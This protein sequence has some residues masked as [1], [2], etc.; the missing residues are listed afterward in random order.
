MPKRNYKTEAIKLSNSDNWRTPQWLFDQL[1]QEFN[2]QIDLCADKANA[3][4]PIFYSL[5][6]NAL[7]ENNQWNKTSFANVP[8]SYAKP[9][10]IKAYEQSR[11]HNVTIVILLRVDTSNNW[12]FD[13][14][15]KKAS[16]T[17]F[18]VGRLRF[19]DEQNKPH[20][21][22]K[23][24]NAILVYGPDY[25]QGST[26]GWWKY[27]ENEVPECLYRFREEV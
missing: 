11:K 23:W 22:A 9:F 1:N 16:E 7:D 6:N 13:H 19:W 24:A 4:L 26:V 27:K 21:S 10:L 20:Y 17:R 14:V 5:E 18:I 8:Y 3:K 2:F 12:W 15:V 25:Y